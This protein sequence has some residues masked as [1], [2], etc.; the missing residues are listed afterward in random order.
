APASGPPPE[1][2]LVVLVHGMGRSWLSMLPLARALEREGFRTEC[3]DYASTRHDVPELCAQLAAHV[4]TLDAPAGTRVHFVGHSLG[5]LLIRGAL[6]EQ[7]PAGT[8]RVVM[9]APP[10]QGAASADAWAPWL[11]WLWKPLPQLGPGDGGVAC[12]LPVPPLEIGVIAGGTDGKVDVE[13]TH[14]AG[15][16]DHVVVDAGHSFLMLR[17]DVQELTARF[18]REGRFSS[19]R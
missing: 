9:L 8:G 1:A 5:N 18:L 3:W 7:P 19:Q 14:L 11:G 17:R 13:E 16:T 12:A 4:A 6:G 2:D 10:N 15:E